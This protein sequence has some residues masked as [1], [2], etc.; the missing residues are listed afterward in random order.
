M[1]SG[2]ANLRIR[3]LTTEEIAEAAPELAGLLLDCVAGGASVDFMADLSRERAEAFWRGVARAACNDGRA[4]LVAEDRDGLAGTVQLVLAAADN[5]PHRAEIAKMLVHR[6]ARRRG[7]GRLLMQA[8]EDAARAM[9]R[10]LLTLDTA[11]GEAGEQLYERLGWIR[12]GVIPDHAL[13]PDGRPA[14]STFYYKRL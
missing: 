5:Q 4:L 8:A 12:V 1:E 9:G 14:S 10:T 7:V 11:T 2:T 3:R 13:F 6:R